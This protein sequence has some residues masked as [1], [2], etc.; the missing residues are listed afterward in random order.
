MARHVQRNVTSFVQEYVKQGLSI[1]TLAKRENY[2]PYMLSRYIVE[3]VARLPD[4][5][6]GLTRSMRDPMTVLGDPDIIAPDYRDSERHMQDVKN[7]KRSVSLGWAE[8]RTWFVGF[9]LLTFSR[10]YSVFVRESTTRLALEVQEALD[11][12]PLY[13]PKHDRWR[14]TVGIEYEVALEEMLKSMGELQQ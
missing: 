2:P 9:A 4:G 1:L 7:S 13:G 8:G 3:Q 5:K 12:D 14:H 11:A 10:C 6:K